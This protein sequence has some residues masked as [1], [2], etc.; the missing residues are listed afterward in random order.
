MNRRQPW[1]VDRRQTEVPRVPVRRFVCDPQYLGLEGQVFPEVVR[2]LE[3]LIRGGYPEAV[4][5]WGIGSGKSYLAS[6]GLSYM[7]HSMLC[8]KDPQKTLGLADGAAVT[9][10]VAAPTARHSRDIVYGQV[11]RLVKGSPWFSEHAA[12]MRMTATEMEFPKGILVASGNSSATFATGYNVFGA[13]IDEAAWFPANV[14]EG[15]EQVEELYYALRHRIASRFAGRGLLLMIS[16]PRTAGDF[17][18][19]RLRSAM[20]DDRVF[21]SHRPVWEVRP[22]ASES[23]GFFEHAGLLVPEA[24]RRDFELNPYRALRDLGAVPSTALQPFFADTRVLEEAVSAELGHPFD[25]QGRLAGWFLPTEPGQRYVHVDLGLK[26]DSCGMAMAR[27]MGTPGDMSSPTVVVE[28]MLRLAPESGEEVDISRPRE[29]VLALRGR[30]F[31]I[32]QVSYDGWQS[33]DSRQILAR[34]GLQTKL[35]SV[36]RTPEAY[37]TLKALA[38]EGR[39]V[40]YA[41]EPF[42]SEAASLEVVRG[43]KI[44]HP[45]RGS[46]DVTDAVAGAVSEALRGWQ[47]TAGMRAEVV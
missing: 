13:V 36:D 32:A 22:V 11:G 35:V 10:V 33:A 34:K 6:I 16:S 15:R 21:T 40:L 23:E 42:L 30:G 1:L 2:S 27:C 26:R 39:L 19:R 41:Y 12:G 31:P 20:D 17:F 7:I 9:F 45:P 28:L 46:K 29:L 44:D 3:E 14:E 18:D 25:S 5:C 43:G 24:Y 47:G 4:V 8:L 37:E 38:M